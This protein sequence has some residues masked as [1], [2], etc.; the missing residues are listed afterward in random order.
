MPTRLNAILLI[1]VLAGLVIGGFQVKGSI[2]IWQEARD[3]E[4]VAK[5][6]AAAEEYAT[7][8]L[9]E[10]DNSAEPLLNG[11]R[12]NK[13]VQQARDFTDEK[14]DAFHQEVVGMPSGQSLE[15]HLRL[16]KDAESNLEKIRDA[17][18]TR[19]MEPVQ[20]EEG[21][22]EVEHH[23][24]EFTNELDFELGTDLDT[25]TGTGTAYGRTVYA[26]ALA[27]SAASLQRST[28]MHLL[29]KPS[30]DERTLRRQVTA[31]SSYAY[32]EDVAVQAY[33]SGG[34]QQDAARLKQVMTQQTE[35][36]RKQLAEAAQQSQDE[37]RSV[38]TPPSLDDMIQL[39]GSGRTPDRLKEQGVTPEAYMAS[40]TLKFDGYDE[41]ETELINRAVDEAGQTASAAQRD[42]FLHGAVVLLA[43]LAAFLL[44]AFMARPMSRSMRRLRNAAFVVAEQRLPMLVDQLSRTDPGRVD[45]RVAPLPVTG[46]DEIGEV[47]RAFDQVH[48]EAVRLATEQA[49]LRSNVNAVFTNLSRRNQSLVEGQLTLITALEK[50]EADPDQ[51]ESLFKL[52]HLATRMR[53]NG[54]NLLVLADEE[55]D[56]RW[57]QPVLL[58]DV[59][60]AASCEVE[61]YERIELFGVPEAEI[62]G[63]AVK[64]LVHL[65]AELLENAT[66]FSSP[67]TEVRVAAARL[68]DRR[69]MIEIH[70]K[71]IGLTAE[72]FA[73]INHRLA[74]P[75]TVNAAIS[76]HMGLFVVGRLSRRHGI[77]VQLRPSGEQA[78]TTSLV[79]LPDALTLTVR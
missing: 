38:V 53:R 59:L 76:Q 56:R 64:D 70:D 69:I 9:D 21:Y 29:I 25:G 26:V 24:R 33:T 75:P 39:I 57:D 27:K 71:G 19:S 52:D 35:E 65:L 63:H 8:L 50:N 60:R 45:T 30:A 79:M 13:D 20:T 58:V 22:G 36:G 68:P 28:G 17:A 54:E 2:D 12:D 66:T 32:L 10:R 37:G 4:K 14:A 48:R 62:H 6:V 51:L 7:A 15:R 40:S 78:G 72:D 44:A 49:L 34:T 16:V 61:Q 47:A 46:T 41:V 43:L 55:P 31:F 18:Y 5:I 77:H 3:A 11:D 74:N 23:L 73:D 67:Q 42:A 1:P